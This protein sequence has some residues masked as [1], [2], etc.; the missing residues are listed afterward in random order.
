MENVTNESVDNETANMSNKTSCIHCNA[1]TGNTVAEILQPPPTSS[2]AMSPPAPSIHFV[3]HPQSPQ[4]HQNG[5]FTRQFVY[6]SPNHRVVT[7]SGKNNSRQFIKLQDCTAWL[8]LASTKS[9]PTTRLSSSA[10]FTSNSNG[11]NPNKSTT[12]SSTTTGST[13]KYFS[14]ADSA[15]VDAN[16]NRITMLLNRRTSRTST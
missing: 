7:L 5:R 11:S 1:L 8:T 14:S 9:G 4:Q 13:F 10:N 6:K 3:K 16:L 12:A 15:I 2:R